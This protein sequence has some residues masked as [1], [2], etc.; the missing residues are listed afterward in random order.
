MDAMEINP[1]GAQARG[2]EDAQ[3]EQR[4]TS[5]ARR[6]AS[7]PSKPKGARFFLAAD[8]AKRDGSAVVLGAEIATEE[9]A[10]VAAFRNDLPFYRVETW[11]AGAEKKG[12]NM[13]LRKQS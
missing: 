3:R 4:K 2:A 5:K 13:V 8:E 7:L 12:R 11:R 1:E 6:T 10:L 9:E